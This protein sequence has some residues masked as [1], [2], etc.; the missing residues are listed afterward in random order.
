MNNQTNP[1]KDIDNP[2]SE[3]YTPDIDMQ[4]FGPD[5]DAGQMM[6]DHYDELDALQ[7]HDDEIKRRTKLILDTH[8]I[9]CILDGYTNFDSIRMIQAAQDDSDNPF[10]HFESPLDVANAICKRW[11]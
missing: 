11:G 6:S 7:S 1:L 5:A 4:G 3:H 9:I 8:K 10:N 2:R